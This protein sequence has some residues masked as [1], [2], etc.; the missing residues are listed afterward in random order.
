MARALRVPSMRLGTDS[1]GLLGDCPIGRTASIRVYVR[2]GTVYWKKRSSAVLAQESR[3]TCPGQLAKVA[4]HMGLVVIAAVEG[5]AGEVRDALAEEPG[6]MAES[7]DSGQL[8]GRQAQMFL[9]ATSQL[10]VAG[11]GRF[12]EISEGEL[13][14]SLDQHSDCVLNFGNPR[15][16]HQPTIKLF[17]AGLD[18]GATAEIL[19][20]PLRGATRDR[21][22]RDRPIVEPRKA[23]R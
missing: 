22:P 17:D 8:F 2:E 10:A 6:R 13:T 12:G 1:I 23:A 20:K 14:S 19:Q 5:Q 15:Q 3:R 21:L 4:D 7:K 9:A 18:R 16:H 11:A